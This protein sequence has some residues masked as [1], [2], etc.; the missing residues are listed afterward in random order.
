MAGTNPIEHATPVAVAAAL[1]NKETLCP[2]PDAIR[3][4]RYREEGGYKLLV[5]CMNGPIYTGTD[6]SPAGRRQ[7][8]WPGWRRFPGRQENGVSLRGQPSP[9]LIAVNADEGEPG[10]FKDRYYLET[11]PHRFI[12]GH[13]DRQLGH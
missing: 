9:R 3:Y 8:A 10:T 12:E 2:E 4:A 5:D 13:I 1:K 11:D 6:H 7:P